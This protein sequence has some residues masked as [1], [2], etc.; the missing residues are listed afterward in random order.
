MIFYDDFMK[1]YLLLYI[2][3]KIRYVLLHYS[4]KQKNTPITDIRENA[5]VELEKLKD[6]TPVFPL[7]LCTACLLVAY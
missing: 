7:L 2:S 6:K 1:Y 5:N 4:D 3:L